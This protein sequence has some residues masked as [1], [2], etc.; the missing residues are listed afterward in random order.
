MERCHKFLEKLYKRDYPYYRVGYEN[1]RREEA[2][3][4]QVS[5]YVQT[6]WRVFLLSRSASS[7]EKLARESGRGEIVFM[8]GCG[9]L[10]MNLWNVAFISEGKEWVLL[11]PE[12]EPLND[13]Q[14]RCLI[15]WSCARDNS[16]LAEI[17][18]RQRVVYPYQIATLRFRVPSLESLEARKPHRHVFLS[19]AEGR[20]E[21]IGHLIEFAVY[22]K[23]LCR[24]GLATKDNL[25]TAVPQFSDVRHLYRLRV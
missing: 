1:H 9:D 18:K 17:A 23:Q 8:Q 20:H 7:H 21:S 6:Y 25:R 22:G 15:K 19:D 3:Q 10:T 24:E 14:Y 2:F 13:R 11:H 16:D 4:R 5:R 12:G